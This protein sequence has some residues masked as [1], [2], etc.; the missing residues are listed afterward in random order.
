MQQLLSDAPRDPWG[1]VVDAM[2]TDETIDVA[3]EAHPNVEAILA[4]A[5][6]DQKFSKT[7]LQTD[8]GVPAG[9]PRTVPRHHDAAYRQLVA[10]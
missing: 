6:R 8:G 1:R 7:L 4:L 3:R 5:M 2:S 9:Q 10:A